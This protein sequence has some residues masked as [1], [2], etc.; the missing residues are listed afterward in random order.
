MR[1]EV[2][3]HFPSRTSEIPFLPAAAYSRFHFLR[4]SVTVRNVRLWAESRHSIGAIANDAC[5]SNLAIRGAVARAQHDAAPH[6][7][8]VGHLQ[9]F[10]ECGCC[11][12][13]VRFPDVSVTRS[14][15]SA[16]RS[17]CRSGLL[18]LDAA[19]EAH[20]GMPLRC[21]LARILA[22]VP[23]AAARCQ[24][25]KTPEKRASQAMKPSRLSSENT[26]WRTG[27]NAKTERVYQRFTFRNYALA[28]R[29]SDLL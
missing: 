26:H 17:L 4:N 21:G 24:L 8:A 19:L 5:G 22:T 1:L 18:A 14:H 10:I 20:R 12:L 27:A 16:G 2:I 13:K 15:H 28:S 25:Y 9:T 29:P 7:T 11:L 23:G 3:R 6:E